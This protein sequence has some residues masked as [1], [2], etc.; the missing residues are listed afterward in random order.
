MAVDP[1]IQTTKHA[2]HLHYCL[3]IS[4][5]YLNTKYIQRTFWAPVLSTKYA[6]VQ[7]TKRSPPTFFLQMKYRVPER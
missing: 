7:H 3:Q 4:L 5:P 2:K 6:Q 1:V